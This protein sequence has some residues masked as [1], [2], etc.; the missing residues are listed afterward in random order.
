MDDS[1]DMLQACKNAH[2]NAAVE[3]H[4]LVADQEFLPM[5]L[6]HVTLFCFGLFLLI[7]WFVCS[8]VDDFHDGLDSLTLYV[9]D[10]THSFHSLKFIEK[11]VIVFVSIFFSLMS[12][13]LSLALLFDFA[14][15]C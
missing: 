12:L 2:H 8:S 7:Y 4:F 6:F 9:L 5:I 13:D 11:Y 1:Y 3:T 15:E 14:Q 10:A